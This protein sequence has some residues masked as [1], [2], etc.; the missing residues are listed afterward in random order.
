MPTRSQLKES[1]RIHR[2]TGRTFY[3][4]TRLFPRRIREATYV[5]YAFFRVADDV[6]DTT[7]AVEPA[8][9]RERLEEIR[10]AVLGRRPT[11]EPVLLATRDLLAEYDIPDAEVET[12]VD[13]MI[14]D[15][16]HEPYRTRAALG[17]YMRGSAVAVAN[18]MLA[19]ME[20]AD[21]DRARPHA[22]ALAEAFQ[23]TNFLR[24]VRED[25]RDY[26]RVYLPGETRRAFEV[27]ID[28][29]R[30]GEADDGFRRAMQVELARTEDR[31]RNGVAG[32]RHL[33]ADMQFP[34]LVAAVLYADYHRQIVAQ[35]YD[36]LAE[37]P[38]LS[39]W[40]K[41]SLVARTRLYW[42]LSGDPVAV[43]ERVAEIDSIDHPDVG[44][45]PPV[46]S[47]LQ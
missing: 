39:T 24:D 14:A 20:P 44:A 47:Q 8:A 1:K 29:L 26:D 28:K 30:N 5:L 15:V 32:I 19:V 9:Q 43:F 35:D 37:R 45:L 12:F 42:A 6:V 38:S 36:V 34:V 40:R 27:T 2:S 18:M 22:K 46:E 7:A 4:A 17:E 21:P 16:D 41:L 33:P 31:Y 25:I 13:A 23:L 3:V 10:D 11:D